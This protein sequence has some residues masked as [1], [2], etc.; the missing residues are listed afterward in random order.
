MPEVAAPGLVAQQNTESLPHLSQ[1]CLTSWLAPL[2][3]PTAVIVLSQPGHRCFEPTVITWMCP[4]SVVTLCTM[5]DLHLAHTMATA[6]PGLRSST[7]AGVVTCV[8]SSCKTRLE[9]RIAVI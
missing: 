9:L 4:F 1:V 5:T 6:S 8:M 3:E 2:P 7:W